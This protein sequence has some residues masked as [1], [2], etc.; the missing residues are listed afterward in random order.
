MELA[1]ILRRA[2]EAKDWSLARVAKAA[3]ISTAYLNKLESGNVQQP[4]PHILH[5]LSTALQL[6][7]IELMRVA[8]YVVPATAGRSIPLRNALLGKL[9]ADESEELARYLAWYRRRKR[10]AQK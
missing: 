1:R 4:S 2:R 7:Y 5:R 3:E 6:P 9:T 8:G 10:T